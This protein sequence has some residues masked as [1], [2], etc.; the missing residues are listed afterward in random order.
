M[1][2]SVEDL[3][4]LIEISTQSSSPFRAKSPKLVKKKNFKLLTSI[5][6]I[7]NQNYYDLLSN[8]KSRIHVNINSIKI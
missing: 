3:L 7:A 2:Q 5:F 8:N 4:N 1:I 6:S